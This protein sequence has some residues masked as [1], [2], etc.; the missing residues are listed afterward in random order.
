MLLCVAQHEYDELF[1]LMVQY[2]LLPTPNSWLYIFSGSV[3]EY[4]VSLGYQI[5]NAD[6]RRNDITD[7]WRIDGRKMDGGWMEDGWRMEGRWTEGG[8]IMDRRMDRGGA[9]AEQTWQLAA[10]KHRKEQTLQPTSPNSDERC[11]DKCT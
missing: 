5:P 3:S 8:W 7:G 1:Y 10:W 9:S 11:R 2:L 4:L 6:W